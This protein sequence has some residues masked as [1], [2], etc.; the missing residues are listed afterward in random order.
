MTTN[1][2]NKRLFSGAAGT[3][4]L[5]VRR[6]TTLT[7]TRAAMTLLVM[8]LMTATARAWDGS[9]TA[10]SPYQIKSTADLDQL[11]SDVNGGND[12]GD[13]DV[14]PVTPEA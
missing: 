12:G 6:A 4:A 5:T 3:L 11:A 13:S 10:E 8:M 9:G 2:P 14:T 1:Q 7:V